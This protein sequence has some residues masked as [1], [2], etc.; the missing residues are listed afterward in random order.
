[1]EKLISFQ[2]LHFRS[3]AFIAMP[4]Y[5]NEKNAI[6]GIS[7]ARFSGEDADYFA[8]FHEGCSRSSHS[9]NASMRRNK[10]QTPLPRILMGAFRR[11]A[12]GRITLLS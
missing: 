12:D 2:R 11:I 8:I 6:I 9:V 10:R 3:I 7:P 5:S 1:M 4:L